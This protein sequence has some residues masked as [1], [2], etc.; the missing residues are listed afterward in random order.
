MASV[1]HVIIGQFYKGILGAQWL[2][3]KMLDLR[4]RGRRFELHKYHC[5]LSLSKNINPSL[6]L[7][8]PKKTRPFITERLLMGRKILNQTKQ[9]NLRKT[10]IF[11]ILSKELSENDHFMVIFLSFLCK[12]P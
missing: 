11:A 5:V 8:Q 3:G 10:T 12:I 1:N 9:R 7:V 2:S 4:L 6:V